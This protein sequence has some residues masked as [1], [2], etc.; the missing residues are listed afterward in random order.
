MVLAVVRLIIRTQEGAPTPLDASS[1][2]D[3]G[4]HGSANA[5]RGN[6]ARSTSHSATRHARIRQAV[7]GG[8][9]S[10]RG[11]EGGQGAGG[12]VRIEGRLG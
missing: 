1:E 12:V 4:V 3:G 8:V 2:L 6:G 10:I 11:G 7:G 5:S 9:R